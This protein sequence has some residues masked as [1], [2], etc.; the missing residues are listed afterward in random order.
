MLLNGG[1]YKLLLLALVGIL[2][3]S[4]HFVPIAVPNGVSVK[5]Q[6][7]AA[8]QKDGKLKSVFTE[9]SRRSSNPCFPNN[10]NNSRYHSI[11]SGLSILPI[12]NHTCSQR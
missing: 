8:Q 11:L 4:K 10:L 6:T 1:G 2:L 3:T 7:V 5:G 9:Y 12:C